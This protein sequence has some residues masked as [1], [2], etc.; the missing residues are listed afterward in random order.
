MR[1]LKAL[2]ALWTTLC[3]VP[4]MRAIEIDITNE[5]KY[6]LLFSGLFFRGLSDY[7]FVLFA[8]CCCT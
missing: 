4:G 3:L 6:A 8:D 1:T 5:R 7:D 2:S